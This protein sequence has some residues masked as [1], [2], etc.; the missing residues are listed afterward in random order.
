MPALRK[1]KNIMEKENTKTPSKEDKYKTK[2]ANNTNLMRTIPISMTVT[3]IAK[4][5]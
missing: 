2:E 1:A 3:I 5:P 4:G